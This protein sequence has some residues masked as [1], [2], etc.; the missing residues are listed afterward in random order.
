MPIIWFS[1]SQVA[2]AAENLKKKAIHLIVS[3]LTGKIQIIFYDFSHSAL[4]LGFFMY[5]LFI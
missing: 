2:D 1:R 5:D 4:S 3:F